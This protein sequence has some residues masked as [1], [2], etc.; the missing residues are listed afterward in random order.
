MSEYSLV[1]ASG[2]PRRRELLTNLGLKF[3]VINPGDEVEPAMRDYSNLEQAAL[4]V[5]ASARAKA[6]AVARTLQ[7]TAHR[8]LV[9]GADTVVRYGRHS[10]GKPHSI[11]EA[12]AML[13]SLSG[14]WHYVLSGVCLCLDG[15]EQMHCAHAITKVKFRRLNQDE[16]ES[17]IATGLPLDK[18]GAYGIQDFGSIFVEKLE[19]CYFNVM[20]LP[21][22]LVDSMLK[23][24][25]VKILG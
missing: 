22:S 17:Y 3:E 14:R 2:S 25:G 8:H 20:G 7:A 11:A 19:G 24:Y 13:K 9:I 5:E 10:L 12:R 23:E 21:L 6:G 18:A 15:A 16:I 4:S 1:L